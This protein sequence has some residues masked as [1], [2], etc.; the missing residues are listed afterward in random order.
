[1]TPFLY[2][3]ELVVAD[4]ATSAAWYAK[5]LRRSPTLA[6][7]A[8]GFVLFDCG[9]CRLALKQGQPLP[10]TAVIVFE[11]ADLD[12]ELTRLVPLGIVPDSEVKASPEGYRRAFVRDP[13]GCR[14]GLFAW[15]N[16]TKSTREATGS[17]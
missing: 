15:T 8:G 4:A 1:M 6:D 17:H 12:A 10:G 7:E 11:V 5:L 13:D 2:M 14:V 3:V 16:A 9:G